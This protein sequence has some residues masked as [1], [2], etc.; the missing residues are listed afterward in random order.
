M[1][2]IEHWKRKGFKFEA[3]FP[4]EYDLWVN[5]KTMQKLRRY[6]DGREWLSNLITGVYE[7]VQENNLM[8]GTNEIRSK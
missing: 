4:N 7:I 6:V 1:I 8:G 3:R 2:D 5:Q